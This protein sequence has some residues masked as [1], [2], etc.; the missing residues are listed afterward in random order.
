MNPIKLSLLLAQ[1]A[2]LLRQVRLANLAGAYRTL[3]D[4][5]ARIGRSPLQG[6]VHLRPVD[7]AQERFCVTL[8]ALEQNQSL[9]EEH[10]G[11]DDLVRLADAISCATGMPTQE[12][13]F[14]IGQLA[15]FAGML[16]AELEAS[17]VEFDESVAG[18]SHE[19]NR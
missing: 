11:D 15:E 16:R 1:Q 14:D 19:R 5:A 8:V 6:R 2:E 13:S 10:L 7:P 17:G 9:V 18:P 3:R 4:L 12:C